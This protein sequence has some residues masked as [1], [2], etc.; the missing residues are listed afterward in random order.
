VIWFYKL[1]KACCGS[2]IKEEEEEEEKEEDKKERHKP[3]VKPR[4]SYRCRLH[5][6]TIS[7]YGT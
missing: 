7:L 5:V 6:C 2:I 1:L 4:R 3:R